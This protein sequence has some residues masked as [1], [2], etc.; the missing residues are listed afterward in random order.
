[1]RR[2]A[3][4]YQGRKIVANSKLRIFVEEKLY[5]D[6][7]PEAIAGRLKENRK[8][9]L[10]YVSKDSIYRYIESPYGKNIKSHR[11]KN[12]RHFYRKRTGAKQLQDRTFIDK[13][14]KA[15]EKRAKIGHTE[16]DFIVSGRKG[17][18]VL[19]VVV[20]RMARYSC[21]ERITD[22]TIP[23]VH[24]AFKRIKQ[25]FPEMET[26]TTDNDLLLQRHKELESILKVTIYFCHP[27]HSWEK[28]SVENVNKH[29]RK[30]IPKGSD[31]SKYSKQF[32]HQLEAK[33]NARIMKCLRYYTPQEVM[34]RHRTQREKQK[35]R[36]SDS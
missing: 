3:A 29:I 6:Q 30:R 33:L 34:E 21:L 18:G 22:V 17:K 19:L 13:R 8:T 7:S 1:M 14:P 28:G 2:R 27:Y 26:I 24:R 25:R 5:D 10:S 4:K 9:D 36:R 15:I 11:K 12:K 32:I 31:L 23:A 20:C 35:N 16:A